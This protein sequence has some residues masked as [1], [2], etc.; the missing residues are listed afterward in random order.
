[1]ETFIFLVTEK[2]M[3]K[4]L[5]ILLAIRKSTLPKIPA[6]ILL[7]NCNVLKQS[8]VI[9]LGN[10][11]GNTNVIYVNTRIPLKIQ[12]LLSLDIDEMT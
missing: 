10:L 11:I 8:T 12:F 6:K 9:Y 1:M 3:S 7:N 5:S 4:N 2:K